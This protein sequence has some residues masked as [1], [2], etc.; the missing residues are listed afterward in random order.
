MAKWATKHKKCVRCGLIKY[1]HIQRGYCVRCWRKYVYK[2]YRKYYQE[3]YKNYWRK[4][5]EALK[6]KRA[7]KPICV[8]PNFNLPSSTT[9]SFTKTS[10]S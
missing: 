6:A 3:Y 8:S 4:N 5:K 10:K 9:S 7:E 1:K 2:K